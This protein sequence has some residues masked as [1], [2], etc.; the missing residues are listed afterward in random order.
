MTSERCAFA[1]RHSSCKCALHPMNSAKI[2]ACGSVPEY[3]YANL[4][5]PATA[6]VLGVRATSFQQRK[7]SRHGLRSSARASLFPFSMAS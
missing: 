2:K 4:S 5:I 3:S 6:K 1:R 7:M